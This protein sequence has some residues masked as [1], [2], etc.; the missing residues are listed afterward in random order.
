[1]VRQT[2]H[3]SFVFCLV[4]P[5]KIQWNPTIPWLMNWGLRTNLPLKLETIIFH[6]PPE[7]S[8]GEEVRGWRCFFETC[9]NPCSYPHK[10]RVPC[11]SSIQFLCFWTVL[12]WIFPTWISNVDHI[13]RQILNRLDPSRFFHIQNDPTKW[14]LIFK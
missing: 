11:P 2:N 14:P 4:E 6:P 7:S 10:N 5:L 8:G 13:T 9:W 1:L 3:F 12:G